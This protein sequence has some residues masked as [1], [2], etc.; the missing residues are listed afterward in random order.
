MC[1]RS[2]PSGSPARLVP[3]TID[4]YDEIAWPVALRGSSRRK[5]GKS[6]M[7][8]R[9]FSIPTTARW[10]RG[11]IVPIRPFPSLVTRTTEP[12]SATRK[13]PPETPI[14]AERNFDRR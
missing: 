3:V 8:G 9:T 5:V 10:T 14:P 11:R 6:A 4:T 2:G 13:F 12:V 7:R 1:I